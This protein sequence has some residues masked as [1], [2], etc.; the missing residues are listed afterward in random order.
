L[1]PLLF[2]PRAHL[3]YLAGNLESAVIDHIR[4][5]AGPCVCLSVSSERFPGNFMSSKV[6]V[7]YTTLNEQPHKT[8]SPKRHFLLTTA[9][10]VVVVVVVTVVMNKATR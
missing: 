3:L 6:M 2:F 10:V 8:S 9:I 1:P 4:S 7:K 5:L